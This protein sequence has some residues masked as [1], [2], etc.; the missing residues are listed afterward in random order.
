[1]AQILRTQAEETLYNYKVDL[2]IYG[3][4]HDYERTYPLYQGKVMSTSYDNA[5][6]PVHIVNGAAG[7]REGNDNNFQ[8]PSPDWSA[9]QSG[10]IGFAHMTVNGGGLLWSFFQATNSTRVLEDEFKITKTI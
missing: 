10:S 7:N 8:K 1:M 4:V 5:P 3:H 2:L 9:F 6:A